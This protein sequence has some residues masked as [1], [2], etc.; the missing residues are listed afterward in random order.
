MVQTQELP[1][2]VASGRGFSERIR[3]PAGPAPFDT[4]ACARTRGWGNPQ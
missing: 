1:G 4:H 2:Y 3:P